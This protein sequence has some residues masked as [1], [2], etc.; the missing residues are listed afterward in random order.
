[1]MSK[2]EEKKNDRLAKNKKEEKRRKHECKILEA[3]KHRID[4]SSRFVSV[5]ISILV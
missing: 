4:D 1:M 5:T 3:E 2:F